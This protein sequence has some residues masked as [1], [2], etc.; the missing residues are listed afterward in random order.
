MEA[1]A[2]KLEPPEQ[3]D[4][5]RA[6]AEA[7]GATVHRCSTRAQ[8]LDFVLATLA[9]EGVSAAPG[10]HAVWAPCAFLEGVDGARLRAAGIRL[11]VTRDTAASA[12]AGVSQL[13]LAV[14]DTGSLVLAS[15][16][17]EQRLASSLPP[18]HVALAPSGRMAPDLDAVLRLFPPHRHPY[19]TL[20]TGPSRTADIERVLTIGVHGPE[21]LFIVLV[22]EL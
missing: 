18:V 3:V 15:A 20:L 21:R 13:D 16:A 17:I 4:A 8:A 1:R 11:E 14:A 6:R 22:D 19:L 9:A 12:R 2:P 5:F 7:V 10:C